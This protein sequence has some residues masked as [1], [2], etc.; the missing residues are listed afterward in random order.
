MTDSSA[1]M[2]TK[3]ITTEETRYG[4]QGNEFTPFESKEKFSQDLL[5]QD[6][7]V[8]DSKVYNQQTNNN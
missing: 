4:S 5:T 3:D 6:L 2:N 1:L 8:D 7:R